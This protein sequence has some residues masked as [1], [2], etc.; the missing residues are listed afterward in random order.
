MRANP[1]L[2]RRRVRRGNPRRFV[3]VCVLTAMFLVAPTAGGVVSA[4]T[5]PEITLSIFGT[6]GTNGWYRS[7][8]TVNWQITDPDGDPILST[9]CKLAET[10][11]DDTPGK[12]LTCEATST[13][14]TK[15]I[16]KTFKID[17]TPPAVT[18]AASRVPDANGWYNHALAVTFAG[19]D[20]TSGVESCAGGSYSGPDNAAAAVAGSC[21]D[22][23]GNVTPSALPFKYDSTPPQVTAVSAKRGNRTVQISWRASADTKRIEIARAPGRKGAGQTVVYNGAASSFRDSELAAG[24]HYR[25]R[26]TGF[27]DASNRVDQTLT[28]TASGRLLTP[29]PGEQVKLGTRTVMTWTRVK[30][31]SYYNLQLMRGGKV[32]SV[33]PVRASF[34]LPRSW[35]YNGR[36]YRL[37]PGVY[38]WYVWPGIGRISANR[39]GALLGSS[40]FVVSR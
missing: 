23:A 30:K 3:G 8:V 32:L 35:V 19:T 14:G 28:F 29:A 18:A 39:Y 10:L 17:K 6:L 7:T 13:G 33:W 11:P 1:L 34:Q 22:L 12:E 25:Y 21:R 9:N 16:K 20:A 38:R 31:A 2:L 40:S 27:D 15:I 4:D 37:R 5:P 26:I 36:R 24:R